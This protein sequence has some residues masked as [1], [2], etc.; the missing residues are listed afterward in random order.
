M[1]SKKHNA[2]KHGANA[3]EVMLLDKTYKDYESLR[4]GLNREY[5]PDGT[6][7]EYQVRQFWTC[8]GVD[9]A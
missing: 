2:L 9:D 1:A 3:K 8:S 5:V 7:E 4:E 6:T